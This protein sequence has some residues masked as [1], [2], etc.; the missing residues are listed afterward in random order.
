MDN[1]LSPEDA[2]R[3]RQRCNERPRQLDEMAALAKQLGVRDP[4]L[5]QLDADIA[6]RLSRILSRITERLKGEGGTR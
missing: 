6:K 4:E 1:Q 3:I 5:E 2:E